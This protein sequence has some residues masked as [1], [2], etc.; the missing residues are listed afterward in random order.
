MLAGIVNNVE[1]YFHCLGGATDAKRFR[2][3]E[4]MESC[5]HVD[6]ALTQFS[7]ADNIAIHHVRQA[8]Q[9]VFNTILGPEADTSKEGPSYDPVIC[10]SRTTYT[11]TIDPALSNEPTEWRSALIAAQQRLLPMRDRILLSEGIYSRIWFVSDVDAILP[12]DITLSDMDIASL[13]TGLT[14]VRD[15]EYSRP[16]ATFNSLGKSHCSKQRITIRRMDR[17]QARGQRLKN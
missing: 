8:P 12:P 16:F 15:D 13:H 10:V 6:N 7:A 17:K 4:S 2:S 11:G 1:L 14:S 5:P 9:I 3:E